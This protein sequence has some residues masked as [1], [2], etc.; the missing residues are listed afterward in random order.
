LNERR[1]RTNTQMYGR[2]M[3][4]PRQGRVR[5]PRPRVSLAQRRLLIMAVVAAGC[6]W[7]LWQL[8]KID[9]VVVVAPGRQAEIESEA[10]KII[11][12]SWTQRNLLTL[13]DGDLEERLGTSDPLLRSVEVRRRWLHGVRISAVLKQPSMGWRSDDQQFLLDRDG[14][15]I[16]VL[17]AGSPLP[18]VDDGS[19]LP[20][21][22][23]Q[24]VVPSRF[25]GFVTDLRPGLKSVGI[26]PTALAVKDTTLDLQ[27][28]TDKGYRL[29]MDTSREVSEQVTDLK[30]VLNLLAAQKK[31]PAEYID[32]RIAGKAY[33]K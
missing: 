32:L 13:N 17:A 27:V 23:G 31:A 14:T 11:S 15:A 4:L 24:R 21:K 8:F 2:S 1:V 7:A 25:V 20:V 19:N 28:Q 26:N 5:A 33:Y 12:E 16:G 6:V 29:I 3:P 9:Q 18:V 10:R 22:I 30:A